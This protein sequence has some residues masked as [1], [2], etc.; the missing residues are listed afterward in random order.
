MEFEKQ[1]GDLSFDPR[2]QIAGDSASIA[3]TDMALASTCVVCNWSNYACIADDIIS[4]LSFLELIRE[5]DI[6]FYERCF[7]KVDVKVVSRVRVSQSKN[8]YEA[9]MYL[10]ISCSVRNAIYFVHL[11]SGN[12]YK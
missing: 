8:I 9:Y 2:T 3:L 5:N 4:S 7:N 10:R 1:W 11:D 6:L 12:L